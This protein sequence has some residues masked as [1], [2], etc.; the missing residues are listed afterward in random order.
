M[1][2][3]VALSSLLITRHQSPNL[4][5]ASLVVPPGANSSAKEPLCFGSGMPTAQGLIRALDRMGA[6]PS[7]D[8]HVFWTSV[9]KITDTEARF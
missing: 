5:E 2:I 1:H 9:S 8:R 4:R 7:G 6:G 3:S